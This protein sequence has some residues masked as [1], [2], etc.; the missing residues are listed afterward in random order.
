MI[1]FAM[2]VRQAFGVGMLT[3]TAL[4]LAVLVLVALIIGTH[5]STE[6]PKTESVQTKE[7]E[8]F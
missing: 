1:A 7:E 4:T 2:S 6:S 8:H 3:G 5:D